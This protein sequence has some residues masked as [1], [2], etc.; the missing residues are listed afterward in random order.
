MCFA[1]VAGISF[2]VNRGFQVV[3]A[4]SNAVFGPKGVAIAVKILRRMMVSAQ[5]RR[6]YV[7]ADVWIE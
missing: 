3:E 2:G 4:V 5:C 7:N 6:C 1:I